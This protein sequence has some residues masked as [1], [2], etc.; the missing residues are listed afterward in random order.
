MIQP[1][2]VAVKGKKMKDRGKSK[3]LI[4]R[5]FKSKAGSALIWALAIALI[6]SIVLIAGFGMVQRQQ[7][8]NVQQHIENQAYYSAMSVTRAVIGWFEGTNY[9]TL[10][11]SSAGSEEQFD[12]INWITAPDNR[13]DEKIL[14]EDAYLDPAR[15]ELGKY[16]VYAKSSDDGSEI[17]FRTVATHADATETVI[18]TLSKTSTDALIEGEKDPWLPIKVPDPVATIAS[19]G[20]TVN[21]TEVV[22][23]ETRIKET[24]KIS[25]LTQYNSN[26]A[27]ASGRYWI[28]GGQTVDPNRPCRILVAKRDSSDSI[29]YG[30]PNN[31]VGIV[32]INTTLP[33]EFLIVKDNM[34]ARPRNGTN[35]NV[36]N[37]II[38][39]GGVMD[40]AN[41]SGFNGTRKIYVK[42][43]GRLINTGGSNW[44]L[45]GD[46]YLYASFYDKPPTSS[47]AWPAYT[48]TNNSASVS[49]PNA[50]AGYEFPAYVEVSKTTINGNIIIENATPNPKPESDTRQSFFP[51]I[52]LAP[53]AALAYEANN[54]ATTK[55]I[56]IP[57]EYTFNLPAS[58]R[59][60]ACT[61]DITRFLSVLPQDWRNKNMPL[62]PS[63]RAQFDAI[64]LANE[65]TYCPHFVSKQE[66]DIEYA[67]I[68]W[69][70]RYSRG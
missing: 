55:V 58:V 2:S 28:T 16:T 23:G 24:F 11:G 67:E 53:N 40:A 64:M 9:D 68:V 54:F 52:I 39:K 27:Q 63:L 48:S 31:P 10:T 57:R 41:G 51:E 34:V 8:Q 7:N 25:E 12:F 70:G 1:H 4:M 22:N 32:I 15:P 3:S 5:R 59:T 30:N 35:I 17:V 65:Y 33:I 21:I 18:G 19:D 29:D 13:G 60:S 47:P 61:R 36:E 49:W 56:H 42:P 62:S 66:D 50:G 69:G 20:D 38:E 43:G 46:I 44:V 6:L 26:T 37:I 45:N 14:I